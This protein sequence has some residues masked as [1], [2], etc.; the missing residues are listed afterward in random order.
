MPMYEYQCSC[1]SHYDVQHS[2]ES[3]DDE[4]CPDCGMKPERVYSFNAK[5]VIYNE[6]Y[7]DNLNAYVR[8][9]RHKSRLLKERGLQEIGNEK[10]I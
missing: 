3:R 9:P 6:Y 5:A 4:V 2:V 7:S 10:Q 8:G 1:G